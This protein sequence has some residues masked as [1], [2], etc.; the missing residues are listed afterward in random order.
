MSLTNMRDFLRSAWSNQVNIISV[1]GG[2]IAIVGAIYGAVQYLDNAIESKVKKQTEVHTE[3]LSALFVQRAMSPYNAAKRYRDIYVKSAN[4]DYPSDLR[5]ALVTA[6]LE[7][8]ADSGF[9]EE[10]QNIAEKIEQDKQ[11]SLQRYNLNALA[12]IYIQLGYADRAID[13]LKRA[14][15]RVEVGNSNPRQNLAEAHWLLTLSYLTNNEISSAVDEFLLANQIK[16]ESYRV[17]DVHFLDESAVEAYISDFQIFERMKI[18]NH[19]LPLSMLEF[20]AQL[21]KRTAA[22]GAGSRTNDLEP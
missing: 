16:S 7:S 6:L 19:K 21:Q 17:S 10:F 20:S 8:V 22:Q 12:K 2:I 15:G 9:P 14:I 4:E 1:A 5:E 13:V 18:R 3:L 11:V